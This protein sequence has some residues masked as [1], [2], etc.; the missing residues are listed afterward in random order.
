MYV[1]VIDAQDV[2]AG[3]GQQAPELADPERIPGQLPIPEEKAVSGIAPFNGPVRVV[4]A[5]DHP[6]G[7]LRGGFHC[8]GRFTAKAVQDQPV[9]AVKHAGAS[10]GDADAAAG[11][12]IDPVAFSHGGLF[13][14]LDLR[15][16]KGAGQFKAGQFGR[17][18]Q[19][20][21]DGFFQTS[22]PKIHDGTP[23]G[24]DPSLRSG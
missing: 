10:A 19:A 18:F 23:F 24:K 21:G 2:Q 12:G 13:R 1:H 17:G 8:D 4:P 15:I 6:Q 3:G 7:V 9:G 11:Q 14:Q 20:G 22:E 5:V 16:R